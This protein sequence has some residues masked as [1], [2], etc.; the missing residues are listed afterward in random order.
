M[1]RQNK[2]VCQA[3][4]KAVSRRLGA[5]TTSYHGEAKKEVGDVENERPTARARQEGAGAAATGAVTGTGQRGCTVAVP[6]R[7]LNCGHVGGGSHSVRADPALGSSALVADV[8]SVALQLYGIKAVDAAPVHVASEVPV[9]AGR[10][11]VRR[12]SV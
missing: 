6:T 3:T 11:H 7:A 10:N 12:P 9:A 1:G 5:P 4:C 8:P 2:A